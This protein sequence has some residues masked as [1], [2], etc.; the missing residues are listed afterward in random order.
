[1]ARFHDFCYLYT[2]EFMLKNIVMDKGKFFSGLFIMFG[3]IILGSML[4]KA[5][6]KFG[7]FDRTV[8][9]KGL[10]EMEVKA[11]I[12]RASCRERVSLCV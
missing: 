9:V 3:L 10:C 1:M 11:E 12:G 2:V 6:D 5:V 8:N 4:P 7:G